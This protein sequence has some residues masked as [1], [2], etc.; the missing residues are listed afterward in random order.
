[1]LQPRNVD[2][3]LIACMHIYIYIYIHIYTH[4][5]IYIYHDSF[6]VQYPQDGTAYTHA[7]VCI[8]MYACGHKDVV[9]VVNVVHVCMSVC[10]Y[11]R[12]R[13]CYAY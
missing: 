5:H 7:Y 11:V 12:G 2:V 3:I 4:T 1:M 13:E 9:I 8:C 10:M 6:Q